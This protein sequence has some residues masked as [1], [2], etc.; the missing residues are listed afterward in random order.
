MAEP[1]PEIMTPGEA[2]K[3]FAM[4]FGIRLMGLALMLM[5]VFMLSR[6]VWAIGGIGVAAG[7]FSLFIRPRHLGLTRPR[8]P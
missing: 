6:Q 7:A 8:E 4:Y 2:R 1:P 5:G 3:R